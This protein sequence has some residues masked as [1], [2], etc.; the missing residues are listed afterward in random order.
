MSFFLKK[1][2]VFS[3]LFSSHLV[4]WKLK[5]HLQHIEYNINSFVDENWWLIGQ[6]YVSI[7]PVSIFQT[8]LTVHKKCVCALWKHSCL[9]QSNVSLNWIWNSS[10]NN[11]VGKKTCGK[12]HYDLKTDLMTLL[13][14]IRQFIGFWKE[15]DAE[16]C[17]WQDY[18]AWDDLLLPNPRLF[19]LETDSLGIANGLNGGEK[20]FILVWFKSNG[21][22]HQT[23]YFFRQP[24]LIYSLSLIVAQF[25]FVTVRDARRAGVRLHL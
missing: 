25:S 16:T 6:V 9:W 7:S 10:V 20:C 2:F 18:N 12:Q 8:Y 11:S 1:S 24:H 4:Y 5:K 14:R 17:I 19:E 23:S 3:H 21:L 22:F 13:K 15:R